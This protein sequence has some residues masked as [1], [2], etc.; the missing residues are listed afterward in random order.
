MP[1]FICHQKCF[2]LKLSRHCFFCF[3]MVSWSGFWSY[4]LLTAAFSHGTFLFPP[5]KSASVQHGFSSELISMENYLFHCL[6]VLG[7]FSGTTP[8]PV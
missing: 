8:H 3:R 1:S 6:F 2:I 5:L 4:H 7:L